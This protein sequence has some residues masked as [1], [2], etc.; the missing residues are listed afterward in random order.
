MQAQWFEAQSRRCRHSA[1]F[2]CGHWVIRVNKTKKLRTQAAAGGDLARV[3]ELLSQ[4][5][6]LVNVTSDGKKKT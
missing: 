5:K 4:D 3:A 2:V 1:V 6:G